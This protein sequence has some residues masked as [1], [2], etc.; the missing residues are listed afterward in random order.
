MASKA[1][2]PPRQVIRRHL[3]TNDQGLGEGAT[4]AIEIFEDRNGA[5]ALDLDL[6]CALGRI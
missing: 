3:M 6:S 5:V 1:V 4:V 2:M